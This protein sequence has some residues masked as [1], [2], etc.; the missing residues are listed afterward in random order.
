MRLKRGV[1]PPGEAHSH[2]TA[3][4]LVS[5]AA[6]NI[7][8]SS[9]IDP[10]ILSTFALVVAVPTAI[11]VLRHNPQ[12]VRILSTI[13]EHLHVVNVFTF[14]RDALLVQLASGFL[15]FQFGGDLAPL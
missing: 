5:K 8:K 11:F 9:R 15:A 7:N 14:V 13:L 4:L 2:L 6:V 10:F 12:P 1:T 3:T